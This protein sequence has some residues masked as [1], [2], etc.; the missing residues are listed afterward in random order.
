[1]GW[2]EMLL[3]FAVEAAVAAVAVWLITETVNYFVTKSKLRQLIIQ[4]KAESQFN[5]AVRALIK[6]NN[7]HEVTFDMFDS[8]NK[9]LG[10][11]KVTSDVGIANDIRSE[12]VIIL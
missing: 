10:A 11:G 2:V 7:G 6:N 8:T 5:T 12:D 4:K 3:Q 1:M 9:N